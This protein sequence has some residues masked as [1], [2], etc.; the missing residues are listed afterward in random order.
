LVLREFMK[1]NVKSCKCV[2][3]LL[4]DDIVKLF[5]WT[6]CYMCLIGQSSMRQAHTETGRQTE[7][8]TDR[9]TVVQLDMSA[10]L[11]R[12]VSLLLLLF[13]CLRLVV[14]N[15]TKTVTFT[16]VDAVTL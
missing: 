4:N 14:I 6:M 2:L 9:Q 10:A 11:S 8:Q 7:R 3:R 15:E 1:L 16:C 12:F 5:C 13:V